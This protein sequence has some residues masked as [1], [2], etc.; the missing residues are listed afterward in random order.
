[1]LN[2]MFL[3]TQALQQQGYC[4]SAASMVMHAKSKAFSFIIFIIII[5]IPLLGYS[6]YYF[7]PS[8]NE[9]V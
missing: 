9:S 2:Y 4:V 7:L 6:W 3:R 1:M 5:I 8:Q